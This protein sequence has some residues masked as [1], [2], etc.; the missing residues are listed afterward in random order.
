MVIIGPDRNVYLSTGDVDHNTK[1]QNIEG[2]E[3][4]GTGGILRVTQD[5]QIVNG[6]GI[7]GSEHPLNMVLCIWNTKQLWYGF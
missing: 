5:G 7:L 1:A 6:K 2:P 3:P 4:D